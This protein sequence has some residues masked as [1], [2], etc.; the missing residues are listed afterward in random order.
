MTAKLTLAALICAFGIAGARQDGPEPAVRE[1]QSPGP[2]TQRA[3]LMTSALKRWAVTA[4]TGAHARHR[5]A[6][7]ARSA[8]GARLCAIPDRAPARA[9]LMSGMYPARNGVLGNGS[10][11][12]LEEVLGERATLA[13]HF[14]RHGYH[15]ARVSKVFHM[16]VPGDITAGVSGFD[17]PESWDEVFNVQ[18]PEWASEGF[19]YQISNY[20]LRF[21]RDK[22][23]DLGFGA[24]FYAVEVRGE[25]LEQADNQASER[26][27]QWLHEA[28][29]Q[30][31]QPPGREV[32]RPRAVSGART[33]F[34]VAEQ[35]S[36]P[37]VPGPRRW[38]QLA[39][40]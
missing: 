10:A 8:L 1:T 27:A 25:G 35:L 18:A 30:P 23:Y 15:T 14:R 17:H 24:A 3:L 38:P 11:G 16:R 31:D 19:G 40:T 32:R 36:L 28:A 34:Y 5:R 33:F 6:G 20:R 7:P 26:A 2:A 21:E 29:Q 12:R 22:H 13:E 37:T 9:A 39:S 4:M